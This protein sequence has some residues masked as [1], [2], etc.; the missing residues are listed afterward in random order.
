MKK[1]LL[2]LFLASTCFGGFEI[3]DDK[4]EIMSSDGTSVMKLYRDNDNVYIDWT[5]GTLYML[6]GTLDLAALDFQTGGTFTAGTFTDGTFTVTGGNF[7]DVG[8]ITG[9]DVDIT[10]G[11]GTYSSSGA[12]GAGVITGT[13]FITG[14]DIGIAADTDLI[15]LT[16]ADTMQVNGDLGIG[17]APTAA[18]TL[19]AGTAAAGTGPIKFT[20]GTAL[21]SP[22]TGVMEFHTNRFWVTN[23]SVRKALDRTG[24]VKLTTTTVE[25][26]VTETTVFTAAVP[27]GSWVAG[28]I[29][30]MYMAGNI[31]NKAASAGHDVTIRV[32]VGATEVASIAT[33]AG[34]LTDACWHIEGV[35]IVRAVGGS[36]E[37]AW[38][39]DMVVD[40]EASTE[41]CDV[42]AIDTTGALDITVTAEWDTADAANIFLCTMG[43]MEYK[44]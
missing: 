30:K 2:I 29:L 24:D 4:V 27:A 25:D 36:G 41:A 40:G 28:N 9:S 12:L 13:S 32:Y 37:M 17:L 42:S 10:A 8:N 15:Q 6:G 31:N 14:S 39:M 7:T 5:S 3:T 20:A 43:F 44:N 35:A 33:A 23:K 34:K 18:L 11:T 38:H 26:T 22:E 16:A 1:L 21:T 19:K